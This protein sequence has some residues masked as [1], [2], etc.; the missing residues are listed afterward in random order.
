MKGRLLRMTHSNS[1]TSQEKGSAVMQGI[2]YCFPQYVDKQ[3][4]KTVCDILKN[5]KVPDSDINTV[6][7]IFAASCAKHYK[8]GFTAARDNVKY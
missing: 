4:I 8:Q 5:M 7:F 6:M 3:S 1:L 2:D